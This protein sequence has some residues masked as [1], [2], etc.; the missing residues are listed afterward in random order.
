MPLLDWPCQKVTATVSVV[1]QVA[2]EGLDAAVDRFRCSRIAQEAADGVNVGHLAGD[3]GLDFLAG[4]DAAV[5]I[6]PACIALFGGESPPEVQKIVSL[7]GHED[8]V[9]L[10]AQQESRIYS[11]R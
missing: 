4:F 8:A 7:Q 5:V 1:V 11:G 3:P 10:V 6:E 2:L 9:G